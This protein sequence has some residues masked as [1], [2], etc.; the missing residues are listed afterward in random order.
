MLTAT[1]YSARTYVPEICESIRPSGWHRNSIL[2]PAAG[3]A[4]LNSTMTNGKRTF[5]YNSPA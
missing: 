5:Y 3:I 1:M 4:S 2:P